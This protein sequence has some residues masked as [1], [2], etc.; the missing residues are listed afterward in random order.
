LLSICSATAHTVMRSEPGLNQPDLKLQLQPFSG[1]DRYA[2]RPQDG[3]DPHSGF[4]IGVMALRPQSRGYI[5]I[6][7]ADPAVH[8]RID[9]NYLADERD[10]KTLLAGIRAVRRLVS[11]PTLR[12]LVVRETRPGPEVKTEQQITDYIR[13]TTATTWHVVGTCRIGN[14]DMA[15]VDSSLRVLGIEALRVIDS[16]VFPTVPSSNTNAPTIALGEKGADLV[17][18]AWSG[19]SGTREAAVQA[20]TAA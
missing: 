9:P 18:K 7:S 19:S 3:L 11:M 1:K 10:L 6:K 16:S 20:K 15:V 5:H 13:S 14:D 2:R 12:E 8:P 4:T 17:L